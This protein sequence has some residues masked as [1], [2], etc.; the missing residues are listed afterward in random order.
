MYKLGVT[1]THD[2][3]DKAFFSTSGSLISAGVMFALPGGDEEFWTMHYKHK[4]YFGITENLSLALK[5]DIAW[6]DTYDESDNFPFFEG[7]YAG[8]PSSVRG[9]KSYSIGA[10]NDLDDNDSTIP[11]TFR[12]VGGAEVWFPPPFMDLNESVRL[13]GFFDFGSVS[14]SVAE[15]D[16]FDFED[17][18][19][20][21]KFRYSAGLAV[22]W[23]SPFGLL[24]VSYAVPFNEQPFDETEEFQFTFGSNF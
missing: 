10:G 13:I 19:E 12:V 18:F 8:G 6:G 22:S 2:T 24:N 16:P 9:Y 17:Y 1:W 15:N 23:L 7:F 21:D 3:R 11:G 4:Q 20:T 5:A 14:G